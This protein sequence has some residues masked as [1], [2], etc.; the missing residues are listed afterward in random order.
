MKKI[1]FIL[2]AVVSLLFTSCQTMSDIANVLGLEGKYHSKIGI[3][4]EILQTLGT[5]SD[6]LACIERIEFNED[7][8]IN[9]DSL[10]TVLEVR[11]VG[12]IEDISSQKLYEGKVNCFKVNALVR[13]VSIKDVSDMGWSQWKI[14]D[15]KLQDID[16]SSAKSPWERVGQQ[17]N[18]SF[19]NVE[20]YYPGVVTDKDEL[21]GPFVYKIYSFYICV[22]KDGEYVLFSIANSNNYTGFI[23][24]FNCINTRDCINFDKYNDKF[25]FS[26]AATL[27]PLIYNYVSLSNARDI[28]N[29]KTFNDTTS[30]TESKLCSDVVVTSVI[31]DYSKRTIDYDKLFIDV[32]SLDKNHSEKM[33]MNITHD[34][35]SSDS[36]DIKDLKNKKVRLYYHI[37]KNPNLDKDSV[38]QWN[39]VAI[40]ELNN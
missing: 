38:E 19:K 29:K 31:H 4:D 24:N 35:Y 25:H 20:K 32:Q 26:A 18:L 13:D 39:L 22:C 28:M 11:T 7:A 9:I 23:G 12:K 16:S 34:T 36:F 6:L 30:L 27:D 21:I 3:S 5:E 33:I 10:E 8:T 14:T 37:S 2:S 40:E 15:V 1:F 17:Y